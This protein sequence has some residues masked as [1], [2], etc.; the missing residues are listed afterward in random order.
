M[1]IILASIAAFLFL[2]LS[3]HKREWALYAVLL[4]LPAYLLR[5]SITGIPFTLIE[6]FV[7]ILFFVF[8]GQYLLIEKK[9]LRSLIPNRYIAGGILLF[10]SAAG[11]A[12]LTTTELTAGLGLFKAY[13][14]EPVLLYIV[15]IHTITTPKQIRA[16]LLS[17]IMSASAISII[18]LIQ[19]ITGDGIPEPWNEWPGRRAVSVYGFPNAIG[20]FV[21]PILSAVI[22][23]TIFDTAPTKQRLLFFIPVIVLL[24]AALISARVEGGLVAVIAATGMVLLSTKYR[25]HTLIAGAFG[26]VG[27]LNYA[28]TRAILLFQ[29]V[30]GDV[31]LALWKGTWNLLSHH[32]FTGAGLAGFQSLYD[33]YR[34]D[35]HVELLVYPHNI[36][37][38][39]WAQ[40]G[41]L[42]LIWLIAV[43]VIIV[44]SLRNTY[45]VAALRPFA[46]M[47]TAVFTSIAVYGLVDVPYFKNDLSL[48]FWIWLGILTVLWQIHEKGDSSVK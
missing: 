11:I 39:F 2:G 47:L 46:V 8:L 36:V 24:T 17:L 13:I 27:L 48:L 20:L 35:S 34:L 10:W 26:L 21:A 38:N 23:L 5:F 30:S 43:I 32:P 33:T 41:L 12:L 25:W 3:L 19:Y 44:S 6:V 42:G 31:R 16:V 4:S 45:K 9:P 37:F 1:N 14:I 29:D 7:L 15:F 18:A 28:P 22:A 40:L